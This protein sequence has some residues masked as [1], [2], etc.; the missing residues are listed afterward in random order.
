MTPENNKLIFQN[1]AFSNIYPDPTFV[2]KRGK[3]W[4]D[5]GVDN[6]LPEYV[7]GLLD[8]SPDHAS[9][10][11]KTI[12]FVHGNGLL[13]PTDRAALAMY[14]NG[15]AN[16]VSPN[17]LNEVQKKLIRDLVVH[18]AC[19]LECRWRRDRKGIAIVNHVD[20]SS[21]R[22]DSTEEGYWISDDWSNVR[23]NEPVFYPKLT[24][25]G[26][27]VQ[28]LYIKGPS[29]G[30]N[31]YGL[32][33][34]FA[35]RHSIELQ[36]ELSKWFLN[37]TKNNFFA[38]TVISFDDI[39]TPE[40]QDGNHKA[41]K[42]FFG[43]SEGENV[44]GAM[45]LYGG[46][47]KIEKFESSAGPSDLFNMQEVADQRMRSAHSVAGRGD[48]F[49]LGRGD[50]ATFSSAD[51]LINEFEVYSQ[52]VVR[53]LQ[54]LIVG[55]WSMISAINGIEHQ[56]E[57]DPLVLFA[58]ENVVGDGNSDGQSL[59]VPETNKTDAAQTEAAAAANVQATALN[60]AQVD[61]LVGIIT[62]VGEG[63]IS[64]AT[65]RPLIQAAFPLIPTEQIDAMLSGI[66][67][68]NNIQ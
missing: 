3:N 65:A 60:G 28:Y 30:S 61:S 27:G 15:E 8:K 42:K 45:M 23:K 13:K 18:G 46:G 51:D 22:V 26:E 57:I 62:A 59:P 2:T 38:S 54:N 55:V 21:M 24:A 19:L 5:F 36:H 44:G 43:G 53:P 47:V 58:N 6:L 16:I 11:N 25:D 31:I 67:P 52:L 7:E 29:S 34:Y 39:P 12:S 4:I 32:P 49:G 35:A 20:V 41:L 40:E 17:D 64:T 68:N 37:R 48:L 33:S 1:V 66:Q 50:G 56:W 10:V 9:I 63:R 14:A